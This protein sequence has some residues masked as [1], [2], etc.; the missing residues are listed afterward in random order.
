MIP[1]YVL[2]KPATVLGPLSCSSPITPG[3]FAPVCHFFNS[4]SNPARVPGPYPGH[5]PASFKHQSS[6]SMFQMTVVNPNTS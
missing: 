1:E 3:D 2:T 6:E 4:A 5:A